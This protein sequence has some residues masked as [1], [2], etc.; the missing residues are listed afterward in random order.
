MRYEHEPKDLNVI[1][2]RVM[3]DG[4]DVILRRQPI[5]NGVLCFVLPAGETAE[6]MELDESMLWA[7]VT[8][9]EGGRAVDGTKI[10]G[11]KSHGQLHRPDGVIGRL[12]RAR[13]KRGRKPSVSAAE[14]E[15]TEPEKVDAEERQVSVC[16]EDRGRK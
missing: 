15:G 7:G 5:A 13:K 14:P 3:V 6:R 9:S 2:I 1:R 11:T 4:D 12:V 10:Y 16:S 8:L